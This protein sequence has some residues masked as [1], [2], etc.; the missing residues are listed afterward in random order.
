MRKLYLTLLAVGLA[1][2][3]TT[4]ASAGI[5]GWRRRAAAVYVQPAPVTQQAQAGGYRSF[6]YQPAAQP[7]YQYE[8]TPRMNAWDYPKTDARRYNGG[9]N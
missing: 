6:S 5:F 8:T 1:I 3:M 2:T 9:T 7:V 4:D